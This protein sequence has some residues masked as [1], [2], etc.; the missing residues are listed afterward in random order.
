MVY[1][2]V[3]QIDLMTPADFSF[4]ETLQAH[5]WR[6]LL[7]F[8]WQEE[9]TTLERVERL[10]NGRVVLLRVHEEGNGLRIAVSE[11]ADR[12]EVVAKVRRMLQLD[13]PV[14][15]FHAFCAAHPKLCHVPARRQGRMLVS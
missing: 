5:G 8:S 12:E 11:E 6:A 13:L 1:P 3:M 14:D 2:V 10:D 15:A 4:R 7:P 9:T